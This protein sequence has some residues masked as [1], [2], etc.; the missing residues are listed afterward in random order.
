M[1]FEQDFHWEVG[2]ECKIFMIMKLFLI[3]L[4]C[5]SQKLHSKHWAAKTI[6]FPSS[7]TL[8]HRLHKQQP[9][10]A[11][12]SGDAPLRVNLRCKQQHVITEASYC[13]SAAGLQ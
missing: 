10:N 13:S 11:A 6:Q 5:K 3:Q 9:R 2:D 4:I 7:P 1:Y 8:K 12:S